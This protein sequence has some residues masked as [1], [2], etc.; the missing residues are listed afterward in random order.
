MLAI[1]LDTGEPLSSKTWDLLWMIQWMSV[2]R[3][4]LSTKYVAPIAPPQIHIQSVVLLKKEN[5]IIQS[6]N[7]EALYAK[8]VRKSW[9]TKKWLIAAYN[10]I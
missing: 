6:N 10:L 9:K 1:Q 5:F 3:Y 7:C 8:L 2:V 4:S